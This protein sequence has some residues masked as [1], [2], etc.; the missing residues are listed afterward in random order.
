MLGRDHP[1]TLT[2]RNNLAGAYY[3]AGDL[4]RAIPLLEQTLADC[5][6]VLG[7]DH[8][9]TLHSRNNL[10]SAYESAGD[11]GQAIPLYEQ[12]LTDRERLLGGDHPHTLTSRNNLAY[13][14]YSAGDLSWAIPLFEQTLADRERVLGRDHPDTLTSRNNLAGAYQEAGDLS[15]AIPLHEQTLADRERVLGGDHP[16]T[17]ASRNN[18]ASAYRAAGDLGRAIP[19]YE[20][21]LADCE[22]VLGG[23]HPDTLTSRNNLAYTYQAAGDLGQA[24]PL[25]EQTLT[26]YERVLGGG[27]PHTLISR[28][29]LAAAYQAAGDLGRAIPLYEQTLADR[30]RM[31]G[32]DHPDTLKVQQNLIIALVRRG[33]QLAAHAQ[34]QDQASRE[35]YGAMPEGHPD[36]H[37]GQSSWLEQALACFQEALD[38][39]DAGQQPGLYGVI[40]HDIASTHQVLGDTA[41]AL[42]SYEQAVEAKRRR[43]GE[44]GDLL[45]TM[46]AYSDCLIEA[47]NLT[48]ART[49]LEE[50]RQV[51]SR[52]E[53]SER[54]RHLHRLGRQYEELAG[55]G[56]NDAY[57]EAL[58]LY[59]AVRDLLHPDTDPLSYATVLKDIADIHTA[60]GDLRQAET[61]YAQAIEHLRPIPETERTRASMLITLGRIRLQL[62]ETPTN[63]PTTDTAKQSPDTQTPSSSPLP[64][65]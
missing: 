21:T 37:T 26:D 61:G 47:G 53:A 57:P 15:R 32:S 59:Q 50:A 34:E 18:L 6:R 24:I 48:H 5:E 62:A 43:Q 27:H 19:L 40:L 13:A 55:S 36:D 4:G 7:G 25:Y 3:A 41:A 63:P 23:D 17:L 11:L 42:T 45:I 54:W 20:Q 44:F 60:Q 46:T 52:L 33:R 39:T 51:V 28:N 64:I 65:E 10:A 1:D 2:S 14:Y 22:R 38:L 29:N 35:G 12:T 8:P 9:D 30:E 16:D 58:T 56:M 49:V 31:L